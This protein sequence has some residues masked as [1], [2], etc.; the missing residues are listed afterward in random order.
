MVAENGWQGLEEHV[1]RASEPV[2]AAVRYLASAPAGG[3]VTASPEHPEAAW[4]VQ[5]SPFAEMVVGE[6]E[7]PER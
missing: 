1:G 5:A 7:Q 6:T 2:P 4:K 3:S